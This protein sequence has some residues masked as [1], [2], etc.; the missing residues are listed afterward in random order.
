MKS[1][2]VVGAATM[3][4]LDHQL[5]TIATWVDHVHYPNLHLMMK[6]MQVAW[7]SDL[8]DMEGDMKEFWE[9]VE[10]ESF[11]E[12]EAEDVKYKMPEDEAA[13]QIINVWGLGHNDDAWEDTANFLIR[14]A[15]QWGI[16]GK[17]IFIYQ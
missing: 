17:I 15:Y 8:D 13:Y 4:D 6:F 16:K 5:D 11:Y 2:K 10:K 14:T 12:M 1:N 9:T 7:F 3:T